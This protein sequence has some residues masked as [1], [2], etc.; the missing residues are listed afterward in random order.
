MSL[1]DCMAVFG[2]SVGVGVDDDRLQH[3][4]EARSDI[5]YIPRSSFKWTLPA[6]HLHIH[7]IALLILR[8]SRRKAVLC[9]CECESFET[10]ASRRVLGPGECGRSSGSR[11]KHLQCNIA[12]ITSRHPW[13]FRVRDRW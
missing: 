6:D 10:R 13:D 3:T 4:V 11:Y 12:S 2:D 5:L 7:T 9:G 1:T 8:P